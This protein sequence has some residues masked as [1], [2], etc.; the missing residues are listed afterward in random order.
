[1]FVEEASVE[2]SLPRQVVDIASDTVLG[3]VPAPGGRHDLAVVPGTVVDMVNTRI[4][5]LSFAQS[6]E[7]QRSR[8][9][10][11]DQPAAVVRQHP[12]RDVSAR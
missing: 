1:M 12:A 4:V 9:Q 10:R 3:F 2:R 11:S 5:Y 8:I 6:R 7:C